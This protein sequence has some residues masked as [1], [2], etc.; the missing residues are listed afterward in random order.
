MS[1]RGL[2][3]DDCGVAR[4]SRKTRPKVRNCREDQ[5]D[6]VEWD[7][8]CIPFRRFRPPRPYYDLPP[9]M[10]L[11]AVTKHHN[12]YRVNESGILKECFWWEHAARP[13]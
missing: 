11:R 6:G 12:R 3:E 8:L 4:L 5:M 1:V 9:T 2:R 7:W 13:L 10:R